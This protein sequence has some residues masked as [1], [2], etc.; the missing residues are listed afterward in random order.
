MQKNH[1]KTWR[2]EKDLYFE[3]TDLKNDHDEVKISSMYTQV[4]VTISH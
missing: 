4:T 1:E 2:R 3:F